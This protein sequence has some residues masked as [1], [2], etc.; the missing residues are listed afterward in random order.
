MQR[1]V[2][3]HSQGDG[4]SDRHDWANPADVALLLLTSGTTSRPK[5]VPLTHANVCSS[6]YSSVAALALRETD[7]GIN[8][9]PCFTDM[10]SSLL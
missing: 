9:P 2:F 3:L 7:C 10:V 1:P 8:V 4:G 5:I 6:A